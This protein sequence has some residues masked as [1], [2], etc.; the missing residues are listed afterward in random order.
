MIDHN[1]EIFSLNNIYRSWRNFSS[2]KH[3][4]PDVALFE[5]NLE[6]HLRS[7][8]DDL[9]KRQYLHGSYTRFQVHDRKRRQIAKA[10]VRDRIVHQ[11]VYSYLNSFYSDKFIFHSYSS[12]I[13]KGVDLACRFLR[14]FLNKETRNY[15]QVVW[16]AKSDVRKYFDSVDHQVL[17]KIMAE[18]GVCREILWLCNK[19]VFSYHGTREGKGI[20]LGNV[21]SQVFSNIYLHRLDLYAKETLHI[22]S[23]MRY[24][25]D[26]VAVSASYTTAFQWQYLLAKYCSDNLF[27]DLIS[28]S[29]RKT[30]WGV[31]F[32]GRTFFPKSTMLRPVT[33]FKAKQE[34]AEL[35]R[36]WV[37]GGIEYAEYLAKINSYA[38][39]AK[40]ADGCRSQFT[41]FVND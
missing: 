41:L 23:Y 20:P 24:N 2:D 34:L 28:V 26:I 3:G 21:C 27:I 18:D 4:R 29:L 19:I 25:D 17:L 9:V 30:S 15:S 31:D 22:K 40:K 37:E 14:R 16:V 8:R 6:E 12:R 1:D 35:H 13:E 39:M 7:I 32:L 36:L 38:S 5:L 11:V 33:Y 10:L